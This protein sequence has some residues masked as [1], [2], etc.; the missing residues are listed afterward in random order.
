MVVAGTCSATL[1]LA[2]GDD[3]VVLANSGAQP[4]PGGVVGVTYDDPFVG[5]RPADLRLA[6]L[7]AD[8]DVIARRRWSEVEGGGTEGGLLQAVPTGALRL[9]ATL[10]QPG[11]PISCTQPFDV[12]GGDRLILRVQLGLDGGGPGCALVETVQDWVQGRTGDAGVPYLGLTLAQAEARAQDDGFVT[13]VVGVDGIDLMVTLDFRPDRLNLMLFD[14][15]VVAAYLDGEP[16]AGSSSDADADADAGAGAGGGGAAGIG[17]GAAG[18]PGEA[19]GNGPDPGQ[20][21]QVEPEATLA[22]D[23]E[24]I[25][26]VFIEGFD[27]TM[28]FYGPDGDLVAEREWSDAVAAGGPSDD[29]DDYYDF[30]LRQVVPAGTVRL[31]TWVRLSEGGPIGPPAGPGCETV[32]DVAADDTARV[33]LLFGPDG[34][35]ACAAVTAATAEADALLGLPRG[36]PAPGFVGLA[37]GEARIEAA[38]RGWKVCVLARDGEAV[39]RPA[40]HRPDRVRLVVDAGVVVAAARA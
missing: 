14:G 26:F 35:G 7:T 13:R 21:E 33:T 20:G 8:G 15:V 10:R 24:P 18:G 38:H 39:N 23:M 19:A 29:L 3:G 16:P 28:R 12:A 25:E 9:R 37:E 31:V 17:P 34:D 32:L 22:V 6:F 5:G 11:G 40:C 30:V 2:P 4:A 36:L 27:V 1:L